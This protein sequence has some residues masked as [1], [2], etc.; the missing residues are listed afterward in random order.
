MA[1]IRH[2]AAGFRLLLHLRARG[3]APLTLGMPRVSWLRQQPKINALVRPVAPCTTTKGNEIKGFLTLWRV[4][5]G[6]A[7][8]RDGRAL[9]LA[10]SIG[11]SLEGLV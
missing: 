8:R 3:F 5:V 11:Q 6:A 9:A 4:P 7:S 2:A 1:E 10:F